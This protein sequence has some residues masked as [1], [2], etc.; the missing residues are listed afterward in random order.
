[1]HAYT[2]A[3]PDLL[4]LLEQLRAAHRRQLPDYRQRMDDLARLAAVLKRYGDDIVRAVSADF[5]RRSRHETL[6]AEVMV[7]LDEIAHLR[8]HLRRWMRP[9][10]RGLN[11]AFLPARGEIRHQPLG[12]V[13]IVSPCNYPV[14]LA[15]IPLA[16]A[17]A[18]GNHVLLK[19]SEHTPRTAELLARLLSETFPSERVSVVQG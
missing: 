5:G 15:L 18:A 8:R 12:V 4:P 3:A 1:M 10:R 2:P 11:W 16:D 19:P 13:G 9:E 7:T 17:I 14:Q 6:L